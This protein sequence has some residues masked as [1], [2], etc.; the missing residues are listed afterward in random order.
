[1]KNGGNHLNTKFL[2]KK[3]FKFYYILVMVIV[4]CLCIIKKIKND[5]IGNNDEDNDKENK[6]ENADDNDN[7][8][9]TIKNKD[10]IDISGN[11]K[12]IKHFPIEKSSDDLWKKSIN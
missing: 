2:L 10:I 4:I 8:F 9:N 1:M 12:R 3:Y 7:N 11:G 5:K 6:G